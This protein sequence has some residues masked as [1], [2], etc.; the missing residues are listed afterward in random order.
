M[1]DMRIVLGRGWMQWREDVQPENHSFTTAR[2]YGGL[3]QH[4]GAANEQPPTNTST[5][6]FS[7]NSGGTL[8]PCAVAARI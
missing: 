7:S 1:L 2:S 5:T 3:F 4:W 6:A 8:I